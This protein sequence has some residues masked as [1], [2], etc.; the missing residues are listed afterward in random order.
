[1]YNKINGSQERMNARNAP[2]FDFHIKMAVSVV[3]LVAYHTYSLTP[4][5]KNIV[6]FYYSMFFGRCQE[7]SC[8][9]EKRIGIS[10]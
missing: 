9:Y 2:Y 5:L 3:W 10:V 1:M 7:R 6:Y 8:T 4:M